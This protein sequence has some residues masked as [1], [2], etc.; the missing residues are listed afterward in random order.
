MEVTEGDNI[1]LFKAYG[2][3]DRRLPFVEPEENK[4]ERRTVFRYPAESIEIELRG[5]P[6]TDIMSG[7]KFAV[8][9]RVTIV[10]K[11]LKGCGR[12]LY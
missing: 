6:C 11:V 12:A 8:S 4:E 1:Q 9:V 7:E 10:D 2:E 3:I 5:E